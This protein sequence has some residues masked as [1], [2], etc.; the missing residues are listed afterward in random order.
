[1]RAVPPPQLTPP[2]G[3]NVSRRPA[4]TNTASLMRD[5]LMASLPAHLR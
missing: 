1:M 4:L 2:L 5:P 3:G